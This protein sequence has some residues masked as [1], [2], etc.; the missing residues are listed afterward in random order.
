MNDI[1]N[2]LKE[3]LKAMNDSFKIEVTVSEDIDDEQIAHRLI[4]SEKKN[5]CE[6]FL[7]SFCSL[8]GP[9]IT[10][11]TNEEKELRNLMKSKY[12]PK[13]IITNYPDL[14]IKIRDEIY[15]K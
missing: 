15:K 5:D 12:C 7:E 9:L 4:I 3:V 6:A 1:E 13:Y 8:F 10:A 11:I 14:A 2:K